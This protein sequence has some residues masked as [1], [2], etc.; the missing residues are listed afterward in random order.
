MKYVKV[1]LCLAVV[2]SLAFIATEGVKGTQCTKEV[3][4]H[5]CTKEACDATKMWKCITERNPYLG[6]HYWPGKDGFY[7]G[8]EPHGAILRTF[9]SP[10]AYLDITNKKGEFS[11]GA[12]IVK[13][14]YS[15]EKELKAI[16]IM[17]KVEGY[18][19]EH[20]DW[21]WVKY[22]PDGKPLKEGK[23]EGCIKCHSEAKDN[24]YAFS[25]KLK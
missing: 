2:F 19:P 8:T 10:K 4:A 5:Q 13:E 23:V 24:D 20:N 11:Y 18:N 22:A 14:N 9:V 25:G 1:F 21:Y 7:E 6:F 17:K 12:L 3:K 15:P 16:T